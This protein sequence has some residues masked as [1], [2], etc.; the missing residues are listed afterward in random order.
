MKSNYPTNKN[1]LAALKEF[2]GNNK[3]KKFV[4]DDLIDDANSKGYNGENLFARLKERL[5]DV[6]NGCSS[7]TVSC[8]VYYSEIYKFFATFKKEIVD[9][10]KEDAADYGETVG[11]YL[12][13]LRGWDDDDLFIE[14]VNQQVLSWYAYEQ[15]SY[16]V[17]ELLTQ[18]NDKA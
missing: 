2:V 13:A 11:A 6:S 1:T 12:S 17:D 18:L 4:V 15:I 9:L 5:V 3:L 8:L 10:I 14:D 16:R 7:G